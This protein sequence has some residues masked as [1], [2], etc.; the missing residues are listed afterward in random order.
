MRVRDFYVC[1]VVIYVRVRN[2]CSVIVVCVIVTRVRVRVVS[3]IKTKSTLLFSYF[4]LS[5]SD[6][7]I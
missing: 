1:V 3:C 4:I 7:K 5:Y 6:L 2:Y